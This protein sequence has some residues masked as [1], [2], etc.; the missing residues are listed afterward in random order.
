MMKAL[1]HQT[2]RG[3]DAYNAYVSKKLQEFAEGK[4]LRPEASKEYL[5]KTLIPEL[6]NHIKKAGDNLNEYFEKL[7]EN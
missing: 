7:I 1:K 6:E 5:E 2:G 4:N 3:H